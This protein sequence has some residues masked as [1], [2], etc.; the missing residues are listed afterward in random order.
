MKTNLILISLSMFIIA[1]NSLGEQK[2]G[3]QKDELMTL[4]SDEH[5]GASLPPAVLQHLV[6]ELETS[7]PELITLLE[8]I[9]EENK[10]D[11]EVKAGA[12]SMLNMRINNGD[13]RCRRI[14]LENIALMKTGNRGLQQDIV[15]LLGK[16]GKPE[17]SSL[18]LD[19]MQNNKWLDIKV[20]AAKSLAQIGDAKAQEGMKRIYSGLL[21]NE[22]SRREQEHQALIDTVNKINGNTNTVINRQEPRRSYLADILAEIN[23]LEKR[24]GAST[25]VVSPS[26]KGRS[27][28]G[29]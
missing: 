7:G 17:D 16:C 3:I 12:F 25:K 1:F 29:H 10:I 5:G 11:S 22:P 14:V 26:D 27:S 24:V 18:L 9:I 8:N 19:V 2:L 15:E 20:A 23:K 13:E 4:L 28:A 21:T 6:K